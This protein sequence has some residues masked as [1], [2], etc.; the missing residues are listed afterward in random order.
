MHASLTKRAVDA[1]KPDPSGADVFLWDSRLSGFGVRLKPSG[2]RSFIVSYYA[3]GLHRVRRRM[4]VGTYG[5]LTV[6][7]AR[8]K[9]KVILGDVAK[10]K[11]PAREKAE[12]RRAVR[13]DTVTRLFAEYI[14]YGE[15]HFK[16]RT[17]ESYGYLSRLYILPA[18]GSMPV[19]RVTRQDVGRLHLELRAKPHTANRVLQLVKAFFY[20]LDSRGVFAGANPARGIE[21]YTEASRERFLSVEEVTRIGQALAVAERVGLAPA[22]A[23]KG[24]IDAQNNKRK[25]PGNPRPRNTGMFTSE[26]HPAN[27]VA[28]AALRFLLLTGW[29]EQEALTLAWSDVNLETGIATLLDTKSGKSV[30]PIGAPALELLDA[31]P[32]VKD[33]PYVFPG[34][35]PKKP[36]ESVSGLWTAVRHAAGLDDVRLHDLRHSIASFAGSHGYSLFLIGK[37]LGHKTTRSTERYAH[38]ADDTRKLMADSVGETIQAALDGKAKRQARPRATST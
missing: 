2:V 24:L 15:A 13:E 14:T 34:R 25:K 37:L 7:E 20:W 1:L 35:D 12:G 8:D 30:R 36:L 32:R 3:P 26:V 17:L 4:T 28:V 9:A 21:L 10:G 33:S 5:P 19:E 18:F 11:D 6:E 31:Q 16:P 23:R 29:R 27:P 22:P 38:V